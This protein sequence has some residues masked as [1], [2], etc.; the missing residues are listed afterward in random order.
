MKKKIFD[1][2]NDL[3]RFFDYV[4]VDNEQDIILNLVNNIV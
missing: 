3:N 2:Q 4:F 1:I